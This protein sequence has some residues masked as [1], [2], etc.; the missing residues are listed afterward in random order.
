MWF[1]KSLHLHPLELPMLAK[2]LGKIFRLV[3]VH[4][5]GLG[6]D[7][8]IFFVHTDCRLNSDMIDILIMY[9]F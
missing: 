8:C 9:E 2:D 5:E 3:L 4:R 7:Y 1:C 6:E